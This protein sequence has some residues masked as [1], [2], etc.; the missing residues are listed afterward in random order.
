MTTPQMQKLAEEVRSYGV[1]LLDEAEH[2]KH[3][4]AKDAQF[5]AVAGAAVIDT[6]LQI[7]Q[8]HTALRTPPRA[9]DAGEDWCE[10]GSD[11]WIT[12]KHSNRQRKATMNVHKYV[13]GYE[14]RGDGTDHTP[15]ENER[16]MLEDAIEGYLS[17]LSTPTPPASDAPHKS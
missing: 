12:L 15:T 8:K 1:R 6:V 3:V 14:F 10:M 16:A 7:I 13:N 17:A 2:S 4:G 9:A 11:G 5:A